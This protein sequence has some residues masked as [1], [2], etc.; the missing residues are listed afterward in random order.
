MTGAPPV[1]VP[2]PMPAVTK[3][4]SAPSSASSSFSRS[5]SAAWRPISG[6][7][8]APSP[9]VTCAPSWTLVPA[10]LCCSAWQ[11]VLA[12]MKSTPVRPARIIVLSALPPPPPTPMTLILAPR[13]FMSSMHPPMLRAVPFA[14]PRAKP[15]TSS[16]KP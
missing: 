1:P 13:S 12:A 10:R 11:S 2:P 3:T 6:L 9:L 14:R 5:S 4:M 15:G 8:P 16:A 7:A